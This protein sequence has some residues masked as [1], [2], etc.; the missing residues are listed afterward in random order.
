M[1]AIISQPYAPGTFGVQYGYIE[2]SPDGGSS[3]EGV[4]TRI[5]CN[6]ELIGVRLPDVLFIIIV[7]RC[8]NHTI[9]H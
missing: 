1:I 2:I 5:F 7:F 8:H 6:A 9:S 3:A 4:S